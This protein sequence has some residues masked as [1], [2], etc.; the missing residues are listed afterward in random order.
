MSPCNNIAE[1]N[2]AIEPTAALVSFEALEGT[3]EKPL[4]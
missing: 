1:L 3:L 2:I 4:H